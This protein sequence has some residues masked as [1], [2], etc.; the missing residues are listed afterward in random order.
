MLV[1]KTLVQ[2]IKLNLLIIL[3]QF[4]AMAKIVKKTKKKVF[5]IDFCAEHYVA[6]Y[7]H[8][9]KKIIK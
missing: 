8:C 2:M 9:T 6:R 4:S 1:A 5:C 7:M 3:W